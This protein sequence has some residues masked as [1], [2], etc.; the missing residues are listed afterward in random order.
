MSKLK[1]FADD[2]IKG[3]QKLKFTLGRVENTVGNG[4]NASYPTFSPFLTM[5]SKGYFPRVALGSVENTVGKA[6][7]AGDLPGS[8]KVVIVW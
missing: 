8:F 1:A 6:E 7:N 5:F 4:E 2:K 3:T